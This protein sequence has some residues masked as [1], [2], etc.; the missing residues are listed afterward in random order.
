MAIYSLNLGFI[1]RSAGRSAVGFSAYISASQQVDERTGVHYDYVCKNDVIVSRILAPEGAPEWAKNSSTLWNKAEQFEDEWAA[2]RFR[3]DARDAEKNQTSLSAREQFVSSAQTAQ[4]IMGAIPIE[5][6][7]LEAEAC[8]EEF[9]QTRFVSRGLIVEYAIHWDR[10]NPHFHGQITRRA[11]VNGEFSERKDRDIVSKPELLITRKQWEVVV[12]KH[13][14]LGGHEVRID[15]RSYE[16][17]GS[18]FLPAHHEGWHAQR[19]AEQGRYSRIVT[20]NEA[21]RQKNIEILCKNPESLIQEVAL[22]RTTFTRRHVEEEIIRRVGGDAKLFS[23]LKAR[24]EEVDMPVDLILKCANQN[25]ASQDAL[26]R[27]VIFEGGELRG[28]AAKLTDRLLDNQDIASKVG[29]N[30]NRDIVF[31]STAYKNQEE[32]LVQ[33]AD[34]L[35]QRSTKVVSDNI[36]RKAIEYGE[37]ALGKSFS[38]EQRTA[39]NHLCSGPDLR[40]LNGKAGTGKTTLLKAV[41]RAYQEAGYEVIGTSF[42]GKAVDIME[43]EVGIPCKT[44]DSFLCAWDKHQEQKDLVESGKLWG[45]PYIYAFNKMKNLEKHRFTSNM[46][47]LVDEANMIGGRLWEPFLTEATNCGAKVLVIQDPAQIK[48]R[49]PGDYGRLFA[50]KFGFCETTEVVRQRVPWQRECSKLLNEHQVLDGLKPYYEKGHFKWFENGPQAHQALAQDYVKDFIANPH[51]TRIALAYQNTEVHTLNQVI[52]QALIEKDCLGSVEQHCPLQEFKIQGKTYSLG[53]RVRFTQNDN[54]GQ[55][56]RNVEEPS[57]LSALVLGRGQEQTEDLKPRS[58]KS[59]KKGVKNGSFGTIE[60]FDEKKSLLT[61]GLD[62]K[63]RVQFDINEY[64]HITLGYAMGNHKSEASTFD[65]G[66][67]SFDPLMDPSTALV[68]MTRHRENVTAYINRE[69][70]IDFKDVVEKL[71]FLRPK[72]TLQDYRVSEDQKPYFARVQHYRDLLIEGMT[73]REEMEGAEIGGTREN[74]IKGSTIKKGSKEGKNDSQT[75]LYKHPA[76][77]AY[78]ACFEERK[79]VAEEILSDWQNHVPYTRLA[80]IRKDVL[81]VEAGL[82]PRLLSDLEYRASIQV[83]GYCDLVKETRDLWRTI[84]QTHPGSLAKSHSLYEGYTLKK[85]DRDSLAYVFQENPK[86]YRPFLR[87]TEDAEG[88]LR[89][90]WGEII[91]KEDRVY[92]SALK[93]QAEAHK[94][95]QLQN[96]Y[97]ERLSPGQKVHYMLV[98]TYVDVRND[99]ASLYSHLQKQDE[100]TV[101]MTSPESA[102]SLEKFHGLQ[103]ERDKLALKIIDSSEKHQAFFDVLNIKEDKLLD[104]AVLGEVREKVQAYKIETDVE[105]RSN[106]AQELKRILT[107]SKDYRI[108]KE[109]GL[110]TNRLTFDIAFYDKVK[111]GEISSDLQPEDVY[112]PIHAYLDSSKQAAQLWKIIHVKEKENLEKKDDLHCNHLNENHSPIDN[113]ET[114]IETLKKDWQLALTARNEN[115]QVLVSQ[116]ASLVVISEMRQ[117]IGERIHRQAGFIQR[118]IKTSSFNSTAKGLPYQN[119]A[120]S[121]RTLQKSHQQPF[122]SIEQVRAAARGNMDSLTTDLLGPPNKHM[123]SKTSLRFGTRGSM[124]VNIAGPKAGQ[125]KDFESGQG[126]DIISLVQREKSLN[127]KEAV[128]YLADILNVRPHQGNRPHH[129]TISPGQFNAQLQSQLQTTTQDSLAQIKENAMRLNAVSELNLKSKPIE[130]TLAQSYLQQERHIKGPLPP[131]L[132]YI[133]KGTTFMYQ[134]ERRTLQHDSLAAFGRNQEGRLSSVQ[135]TKLDIQGKRAL[136]TDGAKLNKIHYG[137]AKGSFVLLQEGKSNDP[138]FIAEGVETALSIKQASVKG[139]I[140]ASMGIY[141]MANYQG[142]QKVQESSF[143]Q[144]IIICADNDDHKSNSQTHKVIEH[145]KNH[146]ESQEK[147]VAI[148]KPNS[149]GDDLNDV[150]K[151]QGISG[152]QEY[153]KPYLDLDRKAIQGLDVSKGTSPETAQTAIPR[154]STQEAQLPLKEETL[155]RTSPSIPQ[156]SISSST[157][158]PNTVAKPEP[159]PIEVISDYVGSLLRKVKHFEG[160]SLGE[161]AKQELKAYLQLLQKNEITLPALKAHN[162]EVAQEAQDFMQRHMRNKSKGMEK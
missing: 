72:E 54:H 127:L 94:R 122:I 113:I 64:P 20:D 3:G 59:F 96:L 29:E 31:T 162:P 126:G 70:F 130:G 21:I 135:L 105:K 16:D 37:T 156:I 67:L 140:V 82:R 69:Q 17:R 40:I 36:I 141:N 47:I 143:K 160:Y 155:N 100:A 23:L 102:F 30:L 110:D 66:F 26:H 68:S 24:V 111:G 139:T 158:S 9:L 153:V 78:E 83:Q 120:R 145:T 27:D 38:D 4:T 95:S 132:R 73:L 51:Q 154:A 159:K 157:S 118:D 117:G 18:L 46:V 123:S 53:D 76:Y 131:D 142:S 146:F 7:K 98:K 119:T 43:Q 109:S 11:L 112:K 8:V 133:P 108:F 5:F 77:R 60:A 87:V 35:H 114:N 107:T 103:E 137:I 134:G 52:R 128:T 147:S 90:Y 93:S 149:P 55:H 41:A 74:A 92:I 62:D 84:S 44:L 12:N 33:L 161:E 25:I 45:R 152:V 80:G 121:S 88:T 34:T 15:C 151:K 10:G 39:V 2:L 99:A 61:V 48:S 85:I 116:Q 129:K 125:W 144:K 150:L 49:E 50:E 136:S 65:K 22:K 71:S 32:N 101:Q 56:I 19:L 81:E 42:Q 138:V 57:F 124:V 91:N 63:R 1:S 13:L 75:A 79:G 115:A 86:L 104:H 58:Q 6:S 106:Q 28:L 97:Y 89:N 14:K 148:I